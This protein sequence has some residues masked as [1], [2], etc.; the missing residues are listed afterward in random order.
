MNPLRSL[1][2]AAL[3]AATLLTGCAGAAPTAVPASTAPAT[4]ATPAAPSTE[5]V[6]SSPSELAAT[7]TY[8]DQEEVRLFLVLSSWDLVKATYGTKD[9]PEMVESLMDNIKLAQKDE[10][11]GQ[12]CAGHLQLL[13][14]AATVASLNLDVVGDPDYQAPYSSYQEVVTIGNRWFDAIGYA[15][16]RFSTKGGDATS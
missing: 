15:E 6:T 9:H 7:C 8:G 16:H 1:A 14:L 13:A 4:P 10:V 3:A 11:G 2:V 12:D 5:G